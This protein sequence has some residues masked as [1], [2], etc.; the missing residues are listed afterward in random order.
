MGLFFEYRSQSLRDVLDSPGELGFSEG[1]FIIKEL[2]TI[3]EFLHLRDIALCSLRPELVFLDEELES[4]RVLPFEMTLQREFYQEKIVY[5]EAERVLRI[6]EDK[7][8]PFGRSFVKG[9]GFFGQRKENDIWCLGFI[10]KEL[11][12]V[13]NEEEVS[14]KGISEIIK[15]SLK[16]EERERININ[17]IKGLLDSFL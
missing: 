13:T 11:F 7:T 1:L 16:I 14:I 6:M 2:I 15:G 5:I 3:L 9:M 8:S 17:E 4:I 12:D 10:I